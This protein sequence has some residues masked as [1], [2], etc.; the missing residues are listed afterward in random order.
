MPDVDTHI[1]IARRNQRVLDYLLERP[2]SCGD[3]IVVVAFHKALHLV[4][5]LASLLG[6]IRRSVCARV[7]HTHS[8]VKTSS[9]PICSVS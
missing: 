2:E 9:S 4:E 5:A 3:W 8:P 7:G 1:W 6:T